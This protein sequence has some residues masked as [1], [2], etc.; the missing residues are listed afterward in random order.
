MTVVND[1]NTYLPPTVTTPSALEITGITREQQMR[2]TTTM[3]SDQANVYV[4]NMVVNLTVPY[5]WGM[6][7]A[8]G[9]KGIIVDVLSNVIT[10][11]IDSTNF[12][13]FSN[14]NDRTVATLAPSGSRNLIYNNNTALS[15]PFRSLNNVGN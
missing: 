12:D 6:W 5:T 10:L 15:V 8:N 4:V 13:I 9:L 3:T 1:A 14:P 7:Q 2:V 11:A